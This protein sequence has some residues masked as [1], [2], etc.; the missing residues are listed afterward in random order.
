VDEGVDEGVDQRVR[1]GDVAAKVTAMHLR[2]AERMCARRLALDQQDQ[3]GNRSATRRFEVANRLVADAR[4]AHTE[5]GPPD[6]RAFVVP[7]DLFPEQQR[8]YEAGARGYLACFG[9]AS[10]RLVEHD[11][12]S[13]DVPGLGARLV[14]DVGI[15]LETD[16]GHELRVLRLGRGARPGIDEVDVRVA[17]LRSEAWATG[18]LSL[19]V[20][21]VLAATAHR[22]SLDVAA[23][24]PE[25]RAWLAERIGVLRDRT[26]DARPTVGADCQGC[27]FVA[28]CP[29]HAR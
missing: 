17:L 3:R 11:A 20:A 27:P 23:Q 8:V 6:P 22:V 12:W 29:P 26:R 28:G 24:L 21:D 4:L 7:R 14:G 9:G 19:V 25:A 15:A 5:G 13:T 18:S 1:A 2:R 16:G 10:A